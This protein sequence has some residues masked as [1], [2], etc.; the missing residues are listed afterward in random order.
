MELLVEALER[1]SQRKQQRQQQQQQQGLRLFAS[2]TASS[3]SLSSS[4][5][6]LPSAAASSSTSFSL[7]TT[8]TTR[9]PF[10]ALFRKQYLNNKKEINK[11]D[12]P[13][14]VMAKDEARWQHVFRNLYLQVQVLRD[15]CPPAQEEEDEE[16]EE[17]G[18]KKKKKNKKKV[19]TKKQSPPPISPSPKVLFSSTIP[20]SD[21]D[22]LLR[23]FNDDGIH[24]FPQKE[25]T[26]DLLDDDDVDKLRTTLTFIDLGDGADDDEQEEDG[27]GGGGGDGVRM[28]RVLTNTGYWQSEQLD[29]N[30]FGWRLFKPSLG[31]RATEDR[32]YPYDVM[33]QSTSSLTYR[34][35]LV[36]RP[37]QWNNNKKK[38][39]VDEEAEKAVKKR[40]GFVGVHAHAHV[41]VVREDDEEFNCGCGD[42]PPPTLEFET[43]L[44]LWRHLGACLAEVDVW[45]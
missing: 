32:F 1:K 40:G 42:C 12:D 21:G 43:K 28:A 19:S 25:G 17:D 18:D 4:S 39:L 34:L 41:L 23:L 2:P 6:F 27:G 8:T 3:S 22:E 38:F 33:N 35:L 13:E 44:E 20:L 15:V 5:T 36:M 24:L 26:L 45:K 7:T 31:L 29:G 37:E 9:N 10:K 30:Q 11:K 16:E 14:T